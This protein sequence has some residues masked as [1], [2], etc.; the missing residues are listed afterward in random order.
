MPQLLIAPTRLGDAI[1]ASGVLAWMAETAPDDPITVACGAP[2]ALAYEG[3]PGVQSIHVMQKK[4]RAGHWI[5]L[6]RAVRGRRW[7]RVVDLRRSLLSYVLRAEARF[8]VPQ[9]QDGE[10][11]V[12]LASRTVGLTPRSP[13]AWYRDQHGAMAARLLPDD[14]PTLAL[15]PGANWICKTW[16]A[17]RFAELTA[18][19]VGEAGPLRGARVL[20]VGGSAE[21]REGRMIIEAVPRA[22]IIDGFGL[23]IPTTAA[24]LSRCALF[25]GNDSA[26]MHLAAAT[27]IRTVGLFGPTRDDLYGPWGPNGIVVRPPESVTALLAGLRHAKEARCLMEGLS[28]AAVV[29]AITARWPDLR[30]EPSPERVA[31][32][33]EPIPSRRA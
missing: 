25:V 4:P 29:S 8:V 19:L 13:T 12:V 32:I 10:H 16:P 1:L 20:L 2:A 31:A 3:A 22:Q 30:P 5:D 26:M 11:R 24:L 33:T 9:A 23:D 6:W 14:A 17:A 21:R 28:A 15:G 7:T 18:S 27:G